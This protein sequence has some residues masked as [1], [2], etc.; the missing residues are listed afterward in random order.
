MRY[1]R[2]SLEE[3]GNS[4]AIQLVLLHANG[5]RFYPAQN[6]KALERRENSSR[7]LLHKSIG[8]GM[9]RPGSHQHAPQAIAMPI[10]KLGGRMHDNIRA[11]LQRSL[12]VRRH[13]SVVHTQV[14]PRSL[15]A[16]F[17]NRADVG[18]LHHGVGRGLN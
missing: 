8:L 15:M 7:A 18:D 10:E 6:E 16:N 14:D 2:M 11:K 17:R 5:Q 13:E 3:A 9:I 1:S 4:P 12:E